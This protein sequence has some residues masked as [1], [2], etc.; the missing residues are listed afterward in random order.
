[1]VVSCGAG[2]AP[3]APKAARAAFKAA[4]GLDAAGGLQGVEGVKP[5]LA[6][7]AGCGATEGQLPNPTGAGLCGCAIAGAAW[8]ITGCGAA[9]WG[10]ECWGTARLPPAL[11]NGGA[12]C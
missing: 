2:A 12:A 10:I 6:A 11:G 9:C 1:L 5:T 4:S 8:T 3:P 7:G